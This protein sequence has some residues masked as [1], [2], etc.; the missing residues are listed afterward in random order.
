MMTVFTYTGGEIMFGIFNAIAAF[1]NNT[2]V[3]HSIVL[4]TLVGG[5][6][7]IM[8]YAH[9]KQ[10]FLISYKWGAMTIALYTVF[11]VP[12]MSVS[13]YDTV[14]GRGRLVENVPAGL[15]FT[16]SLTTTLGH[17]VTE[18]LEAALS[19]PESIQYGK[20]GMMFGSRLLEELDTLKI[21]DPDVLLN[22]ESFADQCIK[23]DILLNHK[24]S[25]QDL[26]TKDN[27]WAF[28]SSH[29]SK[30]RMTKVT[31]PGET[32]GDGV[33]PTRPETKY[34][35]CH[36]AL[37]PLGAQLAKITRQVGR[38]GS[39]TL[40]GNTTDIDGAQFLASMTSVWQFFT[41]LASDSNTLI[42]NTLIK[43]AIKSGAKRHALMGGGSF[44]DSFA[45][46]KAW[47]HQES[48][49]GI[50]FDLMAKQ[51]P[52]L[53]TTLQALIYVAFIF[54]L[55]LS[56]LPR[57]FGKIFQY[58]Q[59][60]LWLQSWPIIYAVI[61]F[62]MTL[63]AA[64]VTK[65]MT[66]SGSPLA[67][68]ANVNSGFVVVGQF[69]ATLVP[70]LAISFMKFDLNS[71]SH[72]AGAMTSPLQNIAGSAAAEKISGN[73]A[74]GNVSLG[75]RSHNNSSAGKV[76]Y[77]ASYRGAG[78]SEHM[79]EG[80][81]AYV[82]QRHS[83]GNAPFGIGG[84]SISMSSGGASFLMDHIIQQRAGTELSRADSD[85]KSHSKTLQATT[86]NGYRK[87]QD[88]HSALIKKSSLQMSDEERK[89]QVQSQSARNMNSA[90]ER[91][92]DS[93]SLSSSDRE[94]LTKRVHG[95]LG[96]S[97]MGSGIGADLSKDAASSTSKEHTENMAQEFMQSREYQEAFQQDMA[98]A[99]SVAKTSGMDEAKTWQESLNKYADEGSSQSTQLN[100][101]KE[102]RRVLTE[103]AAYTTQSGQSTS[104]NMRPELEKALMDQG[105]LQSD[106]YKM[107]EKGPH[108]LRGKEA[109]AYAKAYESVMPSYDKALAQVQS[110]HSGRLGVGGTSNTKAPR[111]GSP[112]MNTPSVKPQGSMANET[113]FN[114]K[115]QGREQV[116]RKID[117]ASPPTSKSAVLGNIERQKQDLKQEVGVAR[118]GA[119][120]NYNTKDTGLIDH[121]KGTDVDWTGGRMTARTSEESVNINQEKIKRMTAAQ[122]AENYSSVKGDQVEKEIKE[123]LRKEVLD[124]VNSGE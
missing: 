34:M 59:V 27:L 115:Y 49:G 80:D 39:S 57:G 38:Q 24:Y 105:Y 45:I 31:I 11:F 52:V 73:Y 12:K 37:T 111:G 19:S 10:D 43:N 62:I 44:G 63:A 23:Y 13:I 84:S 26:K 42:K 83:T 122:K 113:N 6:M 120:L 102:A 21:D 9:Q 66:A 58:I 118:E 76:D 14:S 110:Q 107:L 55:P 68:I 75:N 64:G 40:L 61:N 89:S 97:I 50:L 82:N 7:A 67:S 77:M 74:Y 47:A 81:M 117:T 93:K 123:E 69:L 95:G 51:L 46:Q 72:M 91:F 92:A 98:T 18:V 114:E 101:S 104:R 112:Q 108:N 106:A 71:F 124:S 88:V 22:F 28:L 70:F 86:S 78:L 79:N 2:T 30:V 41:G 25:Y 87:A 94:A 119:K 29:A 56:L 15:A 35:T 116:K 109:A 17:K 85:V 32:G 100:I 3:I 103:N 36:D 90:I 96:L 8:V 20:T 60:L 121:N 4:I 16:A 48:T 99:Q 53:M 65:G 5:A 54:L 33:A 1:F